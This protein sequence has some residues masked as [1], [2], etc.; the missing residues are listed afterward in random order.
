MILIGSK[1]ALLNG[2]RM[3]EEIRDID[4]VGTPEELGRFRSD[5]ATYIKSEKQVGTHRI[6]FEA[7]GA[8]AVEKI[9]FDFEQS[10]TDVMLAGLCVGR[11]TNFLNSEISYPPLDVL[12]FTK[13]AH[14]NIP[15][16][17]DKTIRDLLALKQHASDPK[18]DTVAYYRARKKE[19]QDR[20][21]ANRQ[22]FQLSV[23]NEEFF[24]LSNHIRTYEHDDLH[25]A[26]AYD[27]GFPIYRRCKRDLNKAKIETDL[28]EALSETD[29]LRMVQEEFMVIGVERYYV[30]DKS[31]SREAVYGRGMHKTIRDLFV[32]YFQDFCI[33]NLDKLQAAP[34]FDFLKR[35]DDGVASGRIRTLPNR[36]EPAGPKHKAA[37]ALVNEGQFDKARI[38]AEDMVRQA[39]LPGDPYAL[40]ILGVVMLRQ[41]NPGVAEKCLRRSLSIHN[42]NSECWMQ[43]GILLRN[44]GRT[45]ESLDCLQRSIK[46][47]PKTPETHVNLGLTY[48]KLGNSDAARAAYRMAL[49]LK[50]GAVMAQKRLA[51]LGDGTTLPGTVVSAAAASSNKLEGDA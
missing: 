43:L 40:H 19:C 33:D 28:F 20:Y 50:P 31:L 3:R 41:S 29:Q 36:V 5:N 32:G 39:D 46:L 24:A 13:R 10:P 25:E 26:V 38:A 44:T 12:Y 23:S 2:L 1:A 6:H 11:T 35:F 47:S 48:E 8:G 51:V 9:E 45:K 30:P 4:I 34:E 14:A 22:R 15:V 18:P 17:Y 42:R 16:L 49:S 7:Q 27:Q 37:W 21:L